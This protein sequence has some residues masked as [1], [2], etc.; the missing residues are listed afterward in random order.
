[1]ARKRKS[2][3]K[4]LLV[5]VEELDSPQPGAPGH[6]V[7]VGCTMS[8][9]PYVSTTLCVMVPRRTGTVTR[10]Y[11]RGDDPRVLVDLRREAACFTVEA[12]RCRRSSA[13]VEVEG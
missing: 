3:L 8:V 4:P 13:A 7:K 9:P 12:S 1:M 10:I 6:R 5:P 11:L 2:Q